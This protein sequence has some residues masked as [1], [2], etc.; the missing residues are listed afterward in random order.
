MDVHVMEL[1][2]W[3]QV[4]SRR[5]QRQVVKTETL[6]DTD[7]MWG[8]REDIWRDLGGRHKE[9][10]EVEGQKERTRTGREKE[11]PTRQAAVSDIKLNQT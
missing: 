4:P 11:R 1:R 5:S 2:E 6:R 9:R 8:T 3:T 7:F 10:L